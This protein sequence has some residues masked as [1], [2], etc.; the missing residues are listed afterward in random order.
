MSPTHGEAPRST[1][2]ERG[3]TR[4]APAVKEWLL[5][6]GLG[7]YAAGTAEGI[8][9]RRY[10]GLLIG[11]FPPPE[12]RVLLLAGLEERCTMPDGEI[13]RLDAPQPSGF[14]DRPSSA[15]PRDFATYVATTARCSSTSGS[16]PCSG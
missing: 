1:A 5:T 11:A 10:H 12:G 8:A 6:N 9:T 7:G 2:S 16:L 4:E 14:G 15:I 13:I 3:Q